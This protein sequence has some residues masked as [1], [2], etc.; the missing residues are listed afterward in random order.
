MRSVIAIAVLSAGG[1]A[2][3]SDWPT[4]R[5]PQYR[6][7]SPERGLPLKWSATENVAFRLPLPSAGAATPIVSG[8]RVF[9]TAVENDSVWLWSVD[10]RKG[11][12]SWKQPLGPA[13]G[14]AHRKHNMGSPSP[15]TDGRSV[16][17]LTGSGVLK[18]LALDGRELW[19]LDIQKQYG[20]FGLNW[21]YASSPLLEGGTLYVPV[22]HGMNTDAPSY[23]LGVDAASGRARFRVER[24]TDARAES[25]DAYITPGQPKSCGT[26]AKGIARAP[27]PCHALHRSSVG[28]AS[29]RLKA[30]PTTRWRRKWWAHRQATRTTNSPATSCR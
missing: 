26:T 30:R 21:G 29:L 14:H 10:R 13:A 28:S 3:A 12:V 6:G 22:L 16:F 7:S 19:T 27:C 23:L 24:P 25:P 15:V 20:A 11:A 9:V 1:L 18:G 5:G 17:A 2:V 4:W 8:D